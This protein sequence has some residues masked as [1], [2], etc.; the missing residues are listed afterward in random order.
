MTAY[1]SK[2]FQQYRLSQERRDVC[3]C[4]F[5]RKVT[6]RKDLVDVAVEGLK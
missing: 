1:L 3:V 4:Q 5:Y 2:L 6:V